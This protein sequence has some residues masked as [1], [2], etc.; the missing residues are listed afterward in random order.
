MGEEC[1]TLTNP[2]RGLPPTRC[3]GESGVTSDGMLGFQILQLLHQLVEIGVADFGIVE[4]VVEILVVANLLAQSLDLFFDVFRAG[5]AE[6]YRQNKSRRDSRSAVQPK[7][8]K[9]P[10]PIHAASRFG[11]ELTTFFFGCCF[12]DRVL[13]S[14]ESLDAKVAYILD[15][16][17]RAGL[18][19]KW[20]EYSWTWKRPKSTS[21]LPVKTPWTCKRSGTT[22]HSHVESASLRLAG[23][24]RRLSPRELISHQVVQLQRRRSALPRSFELFLNESSIVVAFLL[25]QGL[26]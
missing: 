17:V 11:T 9:P 1:G 12:F 6:D 24:P 14:S 26:V 8:S 4:D 19:S 15:N 16:P 3:V 18:V 20:E 2:S 22:Q 25:Q 5:I 13:R 23:Q 10:R 7:R 21:T